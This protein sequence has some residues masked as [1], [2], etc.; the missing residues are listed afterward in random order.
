M[1]GMFQYLSNFAVPVDLKH[2]RVGSE[3]KPLFRN[4]PWRGNELKEN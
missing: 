3:Q 1:P 4:H 2:L